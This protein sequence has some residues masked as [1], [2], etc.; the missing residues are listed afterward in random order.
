MKELGLLVHP[1]KNY[2]FKINNDN[3]EVRVMNILN[4]MSIDLKYLISDRFQED[5]RITYVIG[6]DDV[7]TIGPNMLMEFFSQ[8]SHNKYHPL[9]QHGSIMS[10]ICTQ[11][12]KVMDSLLSL[13]KYHDDGGISYDETSLDMIL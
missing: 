9:Y 4:E 3:I 2:M 11:L 7:E 12:I 10:N 13:F 5:N 1:N 8:Y 6:D